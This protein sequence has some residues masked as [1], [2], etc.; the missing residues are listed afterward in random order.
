M[1]A[2][3]LIHA[4]K[5][6]RAVPPL[7]SI[8]KNKNSN[9]YFT[10]NIDFVNYMQKEFM[11]SNT[12]KKL[13]GG[14]VSSKDLL[15]FFSL[16]QDYV[17]YLE[18]AA[19]NCAVDPYIL[20]IALFN[21][22]AS[23]SLSVLKKD[24]KAHYRFSEINKVNDTTIIQATTT[25]V[26]TL[27]MNDNLIKMCETILSIVK[28]NDNFYYLFNGQPASIYRIMKAYEVS[29]PN[30]LQ[31]YKGL[32]EMDPE[33]IAVSTLLPNSDRMLIRYTV[34]DIKNEI[35]AIDKY[36][37]NFNQLFKFVGTVNRQD[38]LD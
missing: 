2:P 18:Q 23:S 20:E 17:W 24:I 21:H 37:D 16:N 14:N 3:Q 19:N 28:R 6:Y 10:Q 36:N 4:G 33:E 12:M 35:A 27:F 9:I 29:Q 13:D 32:G 34:E 25:D 26:N 31:R 5:L 8:P 30:K 7:Y 1:Y 22:I 38:L 15:Y 11:K